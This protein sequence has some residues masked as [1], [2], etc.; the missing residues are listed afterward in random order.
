MI[1]LGF[2]LLAIGFSVAVAQVFVVSQ[3]RPTL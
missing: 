1:E 3:R 2:V